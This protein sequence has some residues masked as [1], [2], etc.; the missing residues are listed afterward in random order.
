MLN[1]RTKISCAL[2]VLSSIFLN[3]TF[4]LIITPTFSY[5]LSSIFTVRRPLF[6]I[7]FVAYIASI[8]MVIE[9]FVGERDRIFKEGHRRYHRVKKFPDNWILKKKSLLPYVGLYFIYAF[10]IVYAIVE[11]EL[12]NLLLVVLILLIIGS[13]F[14]LI[15]FLYY[16]R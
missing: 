2:A 4:F 1:R 15:S 5:F 12:F 16:D 9:P 3:I 8:G 6:I 14:L 11:I 7:L 13:V 10:A